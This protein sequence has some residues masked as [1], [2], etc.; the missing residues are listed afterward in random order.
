MRFD[1]WAPH[2]DAG[3]D[4]VLAVEVDALPVDEPVAGPRRSV[5]HGVVVEEC[6][7]LAAGHPAGAGVKPGF[8]Y[9][10]TDEFGHRAVENVA[11]IYDFH[12]TILH[13]LGLDHEKLTFYHNGIQRRL[14]DV[15]GRV[16]AD[17]L[18]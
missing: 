3:V 6:P 15:H 7:A 10:A 13:L 18:K 17:V 8:S 4:L 11:T 14:T 2:A 12:A 5:A 16:I 1:V 9:G